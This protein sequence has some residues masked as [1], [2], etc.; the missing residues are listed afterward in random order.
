MPFGIPSKFLLNSDIKNEK[1][2]FETKRIRWK[3][4]YIKLEND[5]QTY[6]YK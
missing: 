1:W 4:K 2:N 6:K 5:I 3:C